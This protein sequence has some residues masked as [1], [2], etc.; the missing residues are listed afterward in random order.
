MLLNYY[1]YKS[2]IIIKNIAVN[3]YDPSQVTYFDNFTGKILYFK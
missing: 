3:L 2:V 1:D